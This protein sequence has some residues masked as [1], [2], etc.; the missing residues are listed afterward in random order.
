MMDL[1]EAEETTMRLAALAA[2]L[3][4]PVMVA[5][6]QNEPEETPDI[7][8]AI[9]LDPEP[10]GEGTNGG[11]NAREDGINPAAPPTSDTME[12]GSNPPDMT[13][14]PPGSKVQRAD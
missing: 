2:T 7:V 3:A 13:A 14:P 11:G 1:K 10:D 8:E 9:P 12:H 6:C 4:L 5:A